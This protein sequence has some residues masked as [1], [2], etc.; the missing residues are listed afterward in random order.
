MRRRIL[1]A[2]VGLS[3]LAVAVPALAGVTRRATSDTP[4]LRVVKSVHYGP[5]S[6]CGG[7]TCSEGVVRPL[8]VTTPAAVTVNATVTLTVQYRTTPRDAAKIGMVYAAGEG[9]R[10]DLRP[11][12]FSLAPS[13]RGTSTT[14]TWSAAA[15]PGAGAEYGFTP[16]LDTVIR[17]GNSFDVRVQSMTMVVELWEV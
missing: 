13:V 12:P 9:R 1:F 16:T 5:S 11:G 14:L 6:S 2:V 8:V 7:D 3:L 17:G 10:T 4:L 15:L